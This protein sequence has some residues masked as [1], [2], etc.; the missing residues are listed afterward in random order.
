MF[1]FVYFLR[2]FGSF[3]VFTFSR[4]KLASFKRFDTDLLLAIILLSLSISELTIVITN[5]SVGIDKGLRELIVD[6]VE[7]FVALSGVAEISDEFGDGFVGLESVVS[8]HV[9]E[10]GGLASGAGLSR[11]VG[12][13]EGPGSGKVG[14]EGSGSFIGLL[15]VSL[16]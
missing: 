12:S 1:D 14:F 6:E 11:G 8:P 16:G 15:E 3:L 13:H 2:F 10:V 4:I 5:V 9:S 7:V